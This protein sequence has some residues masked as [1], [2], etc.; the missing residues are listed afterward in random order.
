MIY[1]VQEFSDP[2]RLK[3]IEKTSHQE[4]LRNYTFTMQYNILFWPPSILKA[5]QT[6]IKLLWGRQDMQQ[7]SGHRNFMRNVHLDDWEEYEGITLS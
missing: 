7:N 4:A 1:I 6:N 3:I 5:N 2:N